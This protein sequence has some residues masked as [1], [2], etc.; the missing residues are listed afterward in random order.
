MKIKPRHLQGLNVS[1]KSTFFSG[2]TKTKGRDKLFHPP[3]PCMRRTTLREQDTDSAVP[4]TRSA[5]ARSI[6]RAHRGFCFTLGPLTT[7]RAE[8]HVAALGNKPAFWDKH[9]FRQVLFLRRYSSNSRSP[10]AGSKE[11][12]HQRD[13]TRR[14][15]CEGAWL[16]TAMPPAATASALA[17]GPSRMSPCPQPCLHRTGHPR[18]S[19]LQT[20]RF[21]AVAFKGWNQ[22]RA[23]EMVQGLEPLCW[24]ERLGELGLFSLEKAPRRPYWDLPVLKKGLQERWGQA[25][26]QG[27][28]R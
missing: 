16:S 11:S 28:L 10:Q 7:S 20:K 1:D 26:Y 21:A 12:R 8:K 23:T 3:V 4:R 17:W 24:E 27:L 15:R 13:S 22:Q 9:I 5:S 6:L 19:S 25:F 18:R 2:V 14:G